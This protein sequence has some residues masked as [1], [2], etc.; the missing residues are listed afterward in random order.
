MGDDTLLPPV[1]ADCVGVTKLARAKGCRD[2][3]NE[4]VPMI[5]LHSPAEDLLKGGS[6]GTIFNP[7]NSTPKYYEKP[8]KGNPGRKVKSV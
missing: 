8:R 2:G 5:Q 1:V 6:P 7:D 4:V 3:V